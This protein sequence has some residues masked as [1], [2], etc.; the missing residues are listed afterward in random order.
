MGRA[1]CGKAAH[2]DETSNMEWT[3]LTII[4]GIKYVET[5]PRCK[6]Q[7]TFFNKIVSRDFHVS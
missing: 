2:S 7:S 4:I 3:S 5:Q 6:Q 1:V